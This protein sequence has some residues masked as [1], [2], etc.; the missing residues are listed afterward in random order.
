MLAAGTSLCLLCVAL[1][2][3]LDLLARIGSGSYAIYL[4]HVFFT[5]GARMLLSALGVQSVAVFFVVGLACGIA[6]PLLLQSLAR[7]SPLSALL[8]L[9]ESQRSAAR[10]GVAP[11]A[12]RS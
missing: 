12:A 6:G 3:R 5:A 2:P 4:C 11:Q 9:G 10:R 7:R 8:L 1:R